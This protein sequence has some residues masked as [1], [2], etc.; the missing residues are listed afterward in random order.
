MM[1]LKKIG[2][3]V[4]ADFWCHWGMTQQRLKNLDDIRNQGCPDP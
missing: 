2:S 1:L 4:N 3:M